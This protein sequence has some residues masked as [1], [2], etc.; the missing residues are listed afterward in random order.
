MKK[1]NEISNQNYEIQLDLLTREDKINTFK[2]LLFFEGEQSDQKYNNRKEV[3]DHIQI[4]DFDLSKYFN[5][6][7]KYL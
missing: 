2:K 1:R 4:L 7:R 3:K 6:I 5:Y